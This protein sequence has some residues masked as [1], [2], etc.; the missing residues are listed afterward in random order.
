MQKYPRHKP[1]PSALNRNFIPVKLTNNGDDTLQRMYGKTSEKPQ[2]SSNI[3]SL[4]H[5][6][7]TNNWQEAL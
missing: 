2:G 5:L 4:A 7:I 6:F 1:R 3:W